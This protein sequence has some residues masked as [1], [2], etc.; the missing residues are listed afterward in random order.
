L[1][2]IIQLAITQYLQ[3]QQ[4][5]QHLLFQVAVVVELHQVALVRMVLEQEQ[6]A[7]VEEVP[8]HL[9]SIQYLLDK[10]LHL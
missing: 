1:V 2:H 3:K 10:S 8:L 7:A 9:V 4:Q 5:L 6:V